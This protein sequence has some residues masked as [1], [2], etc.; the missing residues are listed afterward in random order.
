MLVFHLQ[1][2]NIHKRI[3]VYRLF[4][5]IG[6]YT[7]YKLITVYTLYKFIG[8][9]NVHCSNLL[10]Y[11]VCCTLYYIKRKTLNLYDDNELL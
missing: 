7:L 8:V 1:K 11:T 10:E 6:V 2:N 9:Y 3:E 5:L 4:K